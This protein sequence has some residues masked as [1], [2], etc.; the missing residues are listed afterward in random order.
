MSER[1]SGE[2]REGARVQAQQSNAPCDQKKLISKEKR[3]I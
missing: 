2:D 1:G 3:Q